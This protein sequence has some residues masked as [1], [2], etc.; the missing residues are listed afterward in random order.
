M[1][2]RNIMYNLLPASAGFLPGF[3][4]GPED[5]GVC[6]SE[7]F[8]SLQ[9]SQLYNQEDHYDLHHVQ[10]ISRGSMHHL[11]TEKKLYA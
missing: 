8:G 2:W 7:P 10:G 9:T 4:F 3:L 6:S 1:F 11:V 5:G